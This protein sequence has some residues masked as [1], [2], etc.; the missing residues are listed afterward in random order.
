MYII[1]NIKESLGKS[2][3]LRLLSLC[4]YE[5]TSNKLQA[6]ANKYQKDN[7]ITALGCFDENKISGLIILKEQFGNKPTNAHKSYEIVAIAVA[8]SAMGKGVG[9][10][11]VSK[12]MELLSPSKMTAETDNDAIGFY[13]KYGFE[14]KSLGEKYVGIERFLC[15]Y[16]NIE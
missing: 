1:K 14:V 11:L 6:L 7:S 12:S 9:S 10:L 13:R 2:E 4:V 15:T 16:Y 8:P 5:P 3:V